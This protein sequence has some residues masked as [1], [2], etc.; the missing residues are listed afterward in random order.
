MRQTIFFVALIFCF[1][2]S[3]LRAEIFSPARV[4]PIAC[5]GKA[6]LT[7]QKQA[8]GC[9]DQICPHGMDPKLCRSGCL[10]RYKNCK[11]VAGCGEY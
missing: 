10:D 7:C 2:E 3:A 1:S 9:M 5:D 8:Q 4:I 6:A 11:V